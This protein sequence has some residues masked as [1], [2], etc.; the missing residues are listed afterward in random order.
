[1]N[2]AA[3]PG[4]L[5]QETLGF[6]RDQLEEARAA[7][8]RVIA[9]SHQN[10]LQHNPLY[11]DGFVIENASPLARLY[12]EYGVLLQLSGHMHLHHTASAGAGLTEIAVSALSVSPNQ[13]G[14]LTVKDRSLAFHT[15]RTDVESWAQR[16]GVSDPDLLRFEA[17]SNAFFRLSTVRQAQALF[18]DDERGKALSDYL[19]EVNACYFSGRMDLA[20]IDKALLEAW[21][22]Q[23][24]F[25]SLYLRSIFSEPLID[26]TQY[27]T[28]W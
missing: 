23:G 19:S 26:H 9:V 22:A 18:G 17:F 5:T 15:V 13:Y 14:L 6:F 1:M 11:A 24:A 25:F 8:A 21:M 3:A 10:L 16:T 4:R 7:G 27:E 12:E 28:A 20:P 2:T